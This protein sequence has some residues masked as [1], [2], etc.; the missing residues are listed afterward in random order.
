MKYAAKHIMK[1]SM[2]WNQNDSNSYQNDSNLKK[3]YFATLK[4][5]PYIVAWY[6]MHQKMKN[7]IVEKI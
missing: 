4:L 5:R 3:I 7:E 2:Q 6:I 1:C